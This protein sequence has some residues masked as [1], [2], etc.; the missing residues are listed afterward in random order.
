MP[1]N[2][3]EWPFPLQGLN[4]AAPYRADLSLHSPDLANVRA[5]DIVETGEGDR[6]ERRARGGQRGGFEYATGNYGN[7]IDITTLTSRHLTGGAGIV[8][9]VEDGIYLGSS[10]ATLEKVFDP[11]D[12]LEITNLPATRLVSHTGRVYVTPYGDFDGLVIYYDTDTDEWAW[13][14]LVPTTG[15]F[16]SQSRAVCVYRRRI[17]VG[18]TL[19]NPYNWYMSRVDDPL[20]W[21]Y[22]Q[23]DMSAAVSGPRVGDTITAV[24][25][26]QNDYLLMASRH[27]LFLFSGDPMAGGTMDVLSED[28]G[29][30]SRFSWCIDDRRTVYFSNGH[31]VFF[32]NTTEGLQELSS[33]VVPDMFKEI[34][35]PYDIAM[36][37]DPDNK[38][39]YAIQSGVQDSR[40]WFFDFRTA[41][42][43]PDSINRSTVEGSFTSAVFTET[44]HPDPDSYDHQITN[45]KELYE[46]RDHPAHTHIIMNDLNTSTVGYEEYGAKWEPFV[47]DQDG[48]INGDWNYII[49]LKCIHPDTDNVGFFSRVG[50]EVHASESTLVRNLLLEDVTVVGRDRVGGL[51]GFYYKPGHPTGADTCISR[52]YVSGSVSGR[53]DVGGMIGRQSH[54]FRA[55]HCGFLGL[56]RGRNH[57][58]GVYGYF[59]NEHAPA[60]RGHATNLF[61]EAIVSGSSYVGGFAGRTHYIHT[62][63][64]NYAEC[65][66]SGSNY[67]GGFVGGDTKAGFQMLNNYCSSRINMPYKGVFLGAWSAGGYDAGAIVVHYAQY[68][69]SNTYTDLPPGWGDAWDSVGFYGPFISYMDYPGFPYVDRDNFYNSDKEEKATYYDA[70][71]GKEREHATPATTSQLREIT[72]F[73]DPNLDYPWDIE[74]ENDY[75]D[76]A[77]S[78]DDGN[79]FPR[80]PAPSFEYYFLTGQH[81]T[82]V[83]FFDTEQPAWRGLYMVTS[84]GALARM[85]DDNDID[86]DEFDIHSY[87][88]YP[89]RRSAG[90]EM[91][92]GTIRKLWLVM[93]ENSDDINYEIMSG[94]T[95]QNVLLGRDNAISGRTRGGGRQQIHI[96]RMRSPVVALKVTGRA[97]KWAIESVLAE[98][99]VSGRQK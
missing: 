5:W 86:F 74:A 53:D 26:L 2:I 13:E 18:G 70:H 57:V 45:W 19:S 95:Y 49:G 17:V 37:F 66:V 71:L 61:A 34:E 69:L 48:E 96:Q 30:H 90:S 80:I 88:V 89:P 40:M 10:P 11:E 99:R 6:R 20:D 54:T 1:Q 73:N 21:D 81:V 72:T 35:Q 27:S 56:V 93:D 84:F 58:G 42:I 52:C 98:S 55:I 36:S 50:R 39:V 14:D 62:I 25:P 92:I 29:I 75:T 12:H 31:D 43:F 65:S 59:R 85:Q 51:C 8:F 24:V 16:P 97:G 83:F 91:A 67:V 7:I 4:K 15:V 68:W 64:N 38:G 77:W 41:G 33:G 79:D 76:E 87:V 63:S 9:A 3:I 78:I 82:D 28:V 94:D 32:F 60:A 44:P 22:T 47:F 46:I 23:T